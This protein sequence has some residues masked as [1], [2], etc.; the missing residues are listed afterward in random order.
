MSNRL[1]LSGDEFR[2]LVD[3]AVARIATHI[4]SLPD[5]PSHDLEGVAELARSL[6]EPLPEHGAPF[7]EV[8]ELLFERAIPKSFNTAGPGYLA[9]IPGGGILHAAVADLIA[10]AVNRY[11]GVWLAAPGLVQ[12]ETNVIR[13][14]CDMVGYGA[15]SFGIL[16]T[17]GSLANFSAIVTARRDRL[18]SDF[19]SGTLYVSDQV[20]HSVTKAAVLAGFA[21]DAVRVVPTDDGFRMRTDELERMVREDRAS[22]RQP[23][24]VVG[25]AG[26]VNTGAVDDL[27][28]LADVAARERLWFHVDGAYG[29]FFALTERGKVVLRGL[30]RSD[31][32]ALDPH[33]G[34]FAPYGVGCLL[35]K[36]RTALERAHAI[37][38]AY[39]PVMQEDTDFVDFCQI[40]PEL[41]RDYRGL[42]VW[43]PFKLAGARA[44]R[45]ALDE[46]LELARYAVDRLREVD[47]LEIV[48]EP[49]LSIV[50]FRQVAPK[51]DVEAANRVNRNLLDRINRKKRVYLTGTT[52]GGRFVLRICVLSFRTHRERLEQGL[53]DIVAAMAEQSRLS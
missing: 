8:L 18:P 12:L 5:Q 3:A 15:E 53:D 9:Y 47:G 39:L 11:T 20:H 7:E 42:R 27:E 24:L 13:W 40:S 10:D 46:K 50:A 41:S 25:S 29:G 37:Q 17:G 19:L 26:T 43:L 14:F 6:A 31:S 34:L 52:V 28:A 30:D 48:A 35:V 23:F 38:A 32:V 33:K 4:D 36:N 2:L 16:T 1:E 51:Q 45:E 44:F 22:G 21:E 49:Q